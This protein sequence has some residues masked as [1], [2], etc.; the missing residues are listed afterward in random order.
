M[1]LSLRARLL[2]GLV[3]LATVGIVVVEVVTY[4]SLRSFLDGRVETQLD[5][6]HDPISR[7]LGPDNRPDAP[8]PRPDGTQAAAPPAVTRPGVPPGTYG[9]RRDASGQVVAST[10][11]G[12]VALPAVLPSSSFEVSGYRVRTEP[13]PGGQTL[14]IAVPV[15]DVDAT[16]RRLLRLEVAV[17]AAV[18]VGLSVLAWW[19][20]Q[21]GLR[22][23][24]RMGDTAGAIADGDLTQRV[25]EDARTEVGR[26][27]RSLNVM[28]TRIE[29]AF[30]QRQASEDRLRR[31]LADASH[32][33][34]TPLTSIRG[35]AE[36]FRRGADRRPDDLAKAMR[37]IEDEAARM[38]VMVEELLLLAHF[39]QGRPLELEPV[40][41]AALAADAVD[42]ARAASP[43][44]T[45]HLAVGGPVVVAGDAGRLRQVLVNLVGNALRHTPDDATVRVRAGIDGGMAVLEVADDGPGLVPGDED[46][47]F[48]PFYRGDPSRQRDTGGSGLGLAIVA[49]IAA[50]HD[51]RASASSVPGEGATFR[52]TLPLAGG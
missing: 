23:L 43:D 11:V 19:V 44:R 51:G 37:R 24:V 49:A 20:V 30:A 29:E 45:I 7:A 26:L 21:L 32:E 47:V 38:G 40:D 39:D 17:T 6:A 18:L 33:L 1:T 42:D 46:R 4:A 48:E 36:L 35:Y 34:R 13:I 52:V 50:A 2:I 10:S 25:D 22:P 31:F 5:A 15:A 9:E 8:P 14:V 41:L 3:L 28:L 16:L 27:G 12:L